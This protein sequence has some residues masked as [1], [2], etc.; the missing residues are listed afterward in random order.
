MRAKAIV[1]LSVF[2]VLSKSTIVRVGN[3]FIIRYIQNI[4]I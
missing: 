2:I 3:T 1:L 4:V